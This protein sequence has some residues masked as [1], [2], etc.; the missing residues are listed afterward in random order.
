MKLLKDCESLIK[1]DNKEMSDF[2]FIKSKYYDWLN[3]FKKNNI[4]NENCEKI[5]EEIINYYALNSFYVIE[6]ILKIKNDENYEF[7]KN[8]IKNYL[9]KFF[10]K[11]IKEYYI[12][13]E[14]NSLNFFQKY[15]KKKEIIK[16][17]DDIGSYKFDINKIK[18]VIF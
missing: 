8:M 18:G 4:P 3:E 15:K 17:L 2:E 10:A 1:N 9:R 14:F 11:K 16:L 7:F 6:E 12:S 5:V 13:E